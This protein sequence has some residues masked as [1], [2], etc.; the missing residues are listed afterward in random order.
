MSKKF[1]FPEFFRFGSRSGT[2]SFYGHLT[3]IYNRT[4]S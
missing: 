1:P 3:V 4:N 2:L